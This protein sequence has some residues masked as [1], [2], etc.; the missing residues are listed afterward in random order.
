MFRIDLNHAPTT[1]LIAVA[2]LAGALL[3]LPAT[4]DAKKKK[5]DD[6]RVVTLTPFSSNVV[7]ALGIKPVAIGDSLGDP[8]QYSRKLRK[9]PRLPLSHASN[10]PNLEQLVSYE[11]DLMLSERTWRAGHDAVRD[12]DIDVAELDPYRLKDTKRQVIAIGKL[13][14][15]KKKAKKVAK[16]IVKQVRKQKRGANSGPK[17][18][19]LLILGVGQTPYAFLPNSWGGN[20]ISQA[21]GELLTEGLTADGEDFLIS[22]GYAQLSDEEILA[23]NPDIIIA[24]PHGRAEDLDAIA[25]NLREDETFK[26]T[27]AGQNDRIY[28]TLDNRMLQASTK[29]AGMIKIVRRSWLQNR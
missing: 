15:E 2:L 5:K 16:K 27:N 20:L 17:P 12:L 6:P 22:G 4:A 3:G 1:L 10:G 23:R 8:G 18:R 28:V 14:R 26:A 25:T 9:V 24:V 21:G 11:P 7:A 19:V 29:V 13:L